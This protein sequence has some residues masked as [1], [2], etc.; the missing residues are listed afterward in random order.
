MPALGN[1]VPN[2]VLSQNETE[3]KCMTREVATLLG[4]NS[5]VAHGALRHPQQ[6]KSEQ[7]VIPGIDGVMQCVGRQNPFGMPS[8]VSV[9]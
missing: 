5:P 2:A 8:T 1:S 7:I 3:S 9:T 4:T 6:H